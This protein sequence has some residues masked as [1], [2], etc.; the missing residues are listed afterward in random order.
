AAWLNY[1]SPYRP[2]EQSGRRRSRCR[3]KTRDDAGANLLAL[4]AHSRNGPA[5][6]RR[7]HKDFFL[8]EPPC[9]VCGITRTAVGPRRGALRPLFRVLLLNDY[10]TF[11]GQRG[12][13]S[14][15]NA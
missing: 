15:C 6:S 2:R 1:A 13:R 10:A 11:L 5:S 12:H 7:T 9:F 4:A 14:Y 3:K 8:V